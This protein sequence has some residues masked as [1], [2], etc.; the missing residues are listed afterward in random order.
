ME[1]QGPMNQEACEQSSQIEEFQFLHFTDPNHAKSAETRRKVRSHAQ[2]RVQQ[3]LRNESGKVRGK[4]KQVVLD[5][6]VLIGFPHP[7]DLG[8]GRSDP[9]RRYP[10]A[11]DTRAHELYDH[12]ML[13]GNLEFGDPHPK[14]FEIVAD[15][16]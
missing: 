9:F 15:V 1:P 16:Q 10:I 8:A 3:S 13:R 6:S 11:M 7:S 12:C 5:S 2:H 4:S 14:Q